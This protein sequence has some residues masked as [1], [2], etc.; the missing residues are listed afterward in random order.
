MPNRKYLTRIVESGAAEPSEKEMEK[1]QA[2]I[3]KRLKSVTPDQLKEFRGHS[4][5]ADRA[6][7]IKV[8]WQKTVW[9][10]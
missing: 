10:K 2:D 3:L 5:D 9:A 8:S 1:K 4:L 7:E 6:A